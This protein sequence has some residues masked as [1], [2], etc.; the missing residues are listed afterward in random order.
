MTSYKSLQKHQRFV[1]FMRFLLPVLSGGL[2]LSLLIWP[3]LQ[4][5]ADFFSDSLKRSVSPISSKA[6]IDMK[7]V[8]FYSEDKKGQPFTLISDKILETDTSNHIVQLDRPVGEMTLNSG[9]KI[10]SNSSMAL[11]YQNTN[12]VFFEEDLYFKTDNGYN[13]VSSAVFV[14]YKNQLAYSD[15]P[16]QIRGEKADLDAVAFNMRQNGEEVDFKGPTKVVLKNEEK[17]QKVIITSEDFLQ[18]RQKTQTI[19]ALKNVLADDGVNKVYCDEMTAY[20]HRPNGEKYELKSVQAHSNVK[21][22]TQTE[23]IT[24]N[25]A[26]YDLGKEKAF[27]TGNV[28]VDR[29]EG[30]MFG[31]RAVINMKTGESQLEIDNTKKK[32]NNRVKGTIYP[33]RLNKQEE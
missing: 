7:K 1:R 13:A 23:V 21:I 2:V 3:Q 16:I 20:F 17:K 33:T 31:D 6:Q 8:H 18:L 22:I 27:I 10:F 25:D 26:F 28:V 9:V 4:K 19:T 30:K 14:D 29:A 11:F 32:I 15:K 5:K 12:I 24:G